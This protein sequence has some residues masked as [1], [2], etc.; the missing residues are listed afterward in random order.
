MKIEIMSIV[1]KKIPKALSKL[2]SVKRHILV[3]VYSLSRVQLFA[4]PWGPARLL[5]LWNFY[6]QE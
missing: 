6:R 1:K 5:C 3:I 4:T 2:I